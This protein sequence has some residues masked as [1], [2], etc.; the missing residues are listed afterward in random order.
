MT[1]KAVTE[2][3][4]SEHE[5]EIHN[6]YGQKPGKFLEFLELQLIGLEDEGVGLQCF[7]RIAPAGMPDWLSWT[8]YDS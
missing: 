1:Q 4:T 5:R 8:Q 7:L 2:T 6:C 3:C